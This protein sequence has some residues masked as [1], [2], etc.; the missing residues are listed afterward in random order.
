LGVLASS[1]NP[2]KHVQVFL[3]RDVRDESPNTQ[4]CTDRALANHLPDG[5]L[6]QSSWWWPSSNRLLTSSRDSAE[7][8][9]LGQ[10][11]HHTS[12]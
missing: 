4:E 12:R 5:P 6:D 2:L 11:P 3:F 7:A 10:L 9:V 8:R 1:L